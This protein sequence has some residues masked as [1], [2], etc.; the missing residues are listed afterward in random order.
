MGI[1]VQNELM[2]IF[3]Q[4]MDF[5]SFVFQQVLF[6]LDGPKVVLIIEAFIRQ[7]RKTIDVSGPVSVQGHSAGL[8]KKQ[9]V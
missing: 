9:P 6:G 5:Q 7:K 1:R 2:P 8:V 4:L 3:Q